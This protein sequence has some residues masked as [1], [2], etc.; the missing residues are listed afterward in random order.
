MTIRRRGEVQHA[1]IGIEKVDFNDAKF[2][3]VACSAFVNFVEGKTREPH[4]IRSGMPTLMLFRIFRSGFDARNHPKMEG[5]PATI[6]V[7]EVEAATPKQAI[8]EV[9]LRGVT[10]F[11]G[12]RV[13]VE[14]A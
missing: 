13:W 11:E 4:L 12:Q 2:M 3:L 1:L 7:G 8:C 14:K 5:V 9:L 6:M 10:V